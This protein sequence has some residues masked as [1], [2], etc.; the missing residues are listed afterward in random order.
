MNNE[1]V[2]SNSTELSSQLE[3][4]SSKSHHCHGLVGIAVVLLDLHLTNTTSNPSFISILNLRI[5]Y[6]QDHFLRVHLPDDQ[7]PCV[8]DVCGKGFLYKDK[9]NTHKMNKHIR[10]R[11]YPCRLVTPMIGHGG[12]GG[13]GCEVVRMTSGN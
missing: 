6:W 2:S 12:G 10:A 11:P 1:V 5:F 13:G 7:K 9:L 3:N 4:S 8:C